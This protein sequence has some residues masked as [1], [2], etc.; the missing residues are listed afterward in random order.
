MNVDQIKKWL[1][2]FD[3]PSGVI[4]GIHT[5]VIIGLSIAAVVFK[6][7]IPTTVIT[8]YGMVLGGFCIH[9]TTTATTMIMNTS[10]DDKAGEN[11]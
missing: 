2:L 5:L 7:D 1:T 4:L 10:T 11:K 8:L 9:R 3:L 6:K